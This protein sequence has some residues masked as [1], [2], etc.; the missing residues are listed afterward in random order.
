MFFLCRGRDHGGLRIEWGDSNQLS[1][2][3]R[4]NPWCSDVPFTTL[5]H[6]PIIYSPKENETVT[7]N[8]DD[9]TDSLHQ[10]T[11][12]AVRNDPQTTH[13]LEVIEE[14]IIIECYASLYSMVFNQSHLGFNRDR[15]GVSF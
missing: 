9:F 10:A 6:H 8:V 5:A 1:F 3:Q 13:T 4:W 7:Y 15:G 14:P 12:A 2:G 11:L